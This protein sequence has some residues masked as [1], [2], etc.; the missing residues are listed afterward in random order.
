MEKIK[1]EHVT[2]TY[3]DKQDR[4]N[5]FEDLNLAIQP[6]EFVCLIGPSGC[7]KS[8]LLSIIEGLKKP[9]AGSVYIDG[10]KIEGPSSDRG[11]VF[12]HYS[13]F[14]WL[15]A[16]DNVVFGMRQSGIKGK[17]KELR[18]IAADYLDQVGLGGAKEKYPFQ[19]SGGMQQR[20]AIARVMASHASIFLMDEPF[21]AIDPKHRGE[22][23]QLIIRLSKEH[24]KT[25][26]FV[27]HDVEEAILLGDR[28]LFMN[29]KSIKADIPVEISRPRKKERLLGSEEFGRIYKRLMQYFYQEVA[30]KIGDEVVI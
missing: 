30:E 5:A 24:G 26:L 20:V 27:T 25:V 19:L 15:N 18:S 16:L 21:G 3:K 12:Q 2:L 8:S 23:Q 13:L 14:P 11:V 17:K 4:F 28:I 7:G 6:G 29:E 1:L 9:T 10:E 22:L